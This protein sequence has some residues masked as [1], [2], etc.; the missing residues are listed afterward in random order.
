MEHLPHSEL[1][2]YRPLRHMRHRYPC[3][4]SGFCVFNALI[5]VVRPYG[6][7]LQFFY[8]IFYNFLRGHPNLA[9]SCFGLAPN[10]SPIMAMPLYLSQLH[11]IFWQL[12]PEFLHFFR[13]FDNFLCSAYSNSNNIVRLLFVKYNLSYTYF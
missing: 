6:L 13:I 10:I 7:F 8:K 1:L 5:N 9:C 3:K 2:Y 4:R 11:E 12:I